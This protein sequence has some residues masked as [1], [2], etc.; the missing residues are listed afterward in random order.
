VFRGVGYG[1][2]IHTKDQMGNTL[3]TLVKRDGVE[4]D[5]KI[6]VMVGD[7]AYNTYSKELFIVE[8]WENIEDD[9]E[10][11][12]STRPSSKKRIKLRKSG[13]DG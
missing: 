4:T 13:L 2:E 11:E 3:K 7:L 8:D 6:N 5:D 1:Q 9:D 10:L 12:L